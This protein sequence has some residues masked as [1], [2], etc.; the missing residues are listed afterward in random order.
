[1]T[2]ETEVASSIVQT[3]RGAVRGR[4]EDGVHVF[5]GIPYAA[6]PFGADRLRA[7][8]PAEPWD[9]IRD[10]LTWGAEPPQPR[11]A[12]DDPAAG[13]I[14]DP[15]TPGEDCLN[16]N[17]WTPEPGATGLP[18]YVWIP[19][20]MFEVCSGATY[21]GSRFARDGV[22]CVTINYRVG[23][24]GFALLED[25]VPNRGLLDQIAALAWVRDEIAAFGGDPDRITIG[26]ESA[27]AMSIG[28]LLAMPRAE[29]RFRRAILESGAAHRVVDRATAAKMTRE[30]ARLLGVEPTLAGMSTVPWDRFVTATLELKDAMLAN[31]D[32]SRW[33]RETIAS[34]L[35]WQPVI[36]GEVVPERPI[37]RL[38]AGAGRDV[39][40]LVGSNTEDW[41][42]FRVLG[43]DIERVSEDVL[44]G[45]VADHGYLAAAAFGLPVES[46]IAAYR[47]RYPD[48]VPGV[49]LGM[50]QTDWYC[51]IPGIRLAEAHAGASAG[52][53]MYEFAWPSPAFGGALGSC[54]ALELPFVFD[55]LDLGLRQMQGGLLGPE[56]PQA[57]ATHMHAAWV[58]FMRT[59]DPGW[60][61]YE[62]Q[63]RA[64]MRFGTPSSLVMDPR[65]F[66]RALWAG[67]M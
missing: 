51:R 1:M 49:L 46:G 63:R 45:P 44:R 26:G 14:W 39:G 28:T 43:G 10:T 11:I 64:T 38:A 22:V 52:T 66:E 21:D 7:P 55:T 27:G 59:G 61:R 58:R 40:V 50:I 53:W 32:P 19:G 31:P 6:P 36:D 3:T 23:V 9:G 60:P 35:P 29:G 12:V 54:H 15:A 25:G 37:D 65:A 42:L 47:E 8:R 41:L 18:V 17:I 16:L 2:I 57:L 62:P 34:F 56:P 20:G 5:R 48:A 4:V 33:G 67:V 30:L 13:L 24:E